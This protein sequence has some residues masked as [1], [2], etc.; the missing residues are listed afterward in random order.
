MKH[1]LDLLGFFAHHKVAANLLMALMIIGGL[2]ALKHLNVRFYPNFDPIYISVTVDWTGASAEDVEKSITTPLEQSLRSVNDLRRISSTSTQGRASI[3]VEVKEGTD[4]IIALTNVKQKI[5]EFRNLPRD[6][7]RPK[8]KNHARSE[9]VACLLISG[10]DN[11]SELRFLANRF[12]QE[13]LDLGIDI[14]HISGLPEEEVAIEISNDTLKYLNTSLDNI[15]Q[16]IAKLSSDLP[17]GTFGEGENS[18]ALRTTNQQRNAIGFAHLPIT[19]GNQTLTHLGDI[20]T[21]KRQPKKEGITLTVDGKP[22][23]ELN[24]ERP[25]YGDSFQYA[26]TLEQWLAKT[27]K[28]LPPNIT[29]QLYDKSWELIRERITLLLK[30][31]SGGLILVTAI[32]YLFLTTKVAWWVAVGIPI[33]FMATLFILHIAGGSINMISL[34]GLIMALGIIVDDAIVVGED[35]LAHYQMGEAPLKAAEGGARRMF[36]PVIASSLTTIAAFL[37]LMMISGPTGKILFAIPLVVV[38]VILASLI[39]SFF[40]LPSHLRHAFLHLK[41]PDSTAWR[42]RF[43]RSFRNFRNNHF[44]K[45]IELAIQHRSITICSLITLLLIALGFVA[46]QRVPFVYFESPEPSI[47]IANIT[48]APGTPRNQV[49]TFLERM[50]DALRT[51]DTAL[52][53]QNLVL[54][55]VIRHGSGT[56]F[57]GQPQYKGDHIASMTIELVS[58]DSRKIR[59]HQFINAWKQRIPTPPGLDTLII[60]DR[61][62]G[63]PGRDIAIQLSG[64]DAPQLKT[65]AIELSEVLRNIPGVSNIQDDMPYGKEQHVYNLTSDGEALNLTSNE[66][67][68]QLRTAFDGRLVQLFQDGPNEIEVRVRLPRDERTHIN[69]LSKLNIQL[70]NN[71]SAPLSSVAV[72]SSQRGFQVL[73]HADGKLAIEVSGDVNTLI[74]NGNAILAHIENTVLPDLT[75]RYNLSYS[76]QGQSAEQSETMDDITYGLVLGLVLIYLILAWIFASY[77]W[78]LVVMAAIP[79]GLVGALMGHWFMGLHLTMLSLFG[80]FGLSGIVVND[81]IILVTFYQHLK[82]QG[83]PIRTALTQASCQRLRAVLLTTLTTIAGLIPLLFE[84]SVQAQFLIPMATSIAFG[85]GFGS[86]IILILIPVLL[87]YYEE[88]LEQWAK[89]RNNKRVKNSI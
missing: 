79:F 62:N 72:W 30:N 1:R 11:D 6:A 52:S 46:G 43:D 63:P 15:A 59:N 4:K 25:E 12:R 48:F 33:S 5:D 73:K 77:G 3:T 45:W 68:R 2:F 49:D 10:A 89:T 23:I 42:H 39:E 85:L 7:E 41:T 29:L 60:V 27:R 75:D 80:F 9:H 56:S 8:V 51:T 13:L 82:A 61:F 44:K 64:P 21:I 50:E 14:I 54:T 38:S 67:G 58:P 66:L 76:F 35:A 31:G 55:A 53:E 20:A 65:A 87:S 36:A 71:K 19:T 17:A 34:F 84:T 88:M 47:I 26:D 74:N 69:A 81:S 16:R 18:K 24:I 22:A 83:I 37:P 78:P 40:V 57:N 32:L 28:E 70:D 86:I